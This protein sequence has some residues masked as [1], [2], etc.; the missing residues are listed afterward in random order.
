M[1][2]VRSR[3]A[4]VIGFAATLRRLRK[5]RGMTQEALAAA[6]GTGR[7]QVVNLEAEASM[8]SLDLLV[9]LADALDVTTDELLGRK[10]AAEGA[11]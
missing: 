11:G 4:R 8:P 7:T 6:A 1:S 5:A 2:G 9:G 10:S 3:V